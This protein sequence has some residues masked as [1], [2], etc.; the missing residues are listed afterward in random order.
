MLGPHA[1]SSAI[2]AVRFRW[3]NKKRGEY[4]CDP[5]RVMD[6]LVIE[7]AKRLPTSDREAFFKACER[8]FED[9]HPRSS[10]ETYHREHDKR[11]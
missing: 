6:E 4:P 11:P 3:H 5:Q 10:Q 1:I 7:I 8:K 9:A 2:Q